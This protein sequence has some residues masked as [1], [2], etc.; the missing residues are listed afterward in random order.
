MSV[1]AEVVESP[2]G[3]LLIALFEAALLMPIFPPD[4]DL[5]RLRPPIEGCVKAEDEDDE[6]GVSKLKSVSV[7]PDLDRLRPPIEGCVKAEDEEEDEE[8]DEGVS[9]FKS[10]SV[11]P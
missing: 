10:V 9:M 6:E 7:P 11:P 4:L 8:E 1:F 3:P 5:D 2:T